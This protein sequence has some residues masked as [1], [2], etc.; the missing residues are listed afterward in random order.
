MFP[1][2]AVRRLRQIWT[3]TITAVRPHGNA[4]PTIHLLQYTKSPAYRVSDGKLLVNLKGNVGTME[5]VPA[6]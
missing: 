4:A 6:R 3:Y 5:F 1:C 2:T